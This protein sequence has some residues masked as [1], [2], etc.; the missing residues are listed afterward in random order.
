M[1]RFQLNRVGFLLIALV[2][3]AIRVHP[4][5]LLVLCATLASAS[6]GSAQAPTRR[7]SVRVQVI[8]NGAL[9]SAPTRYWLAAAPTFD[10]GGLEDDPE[11]E[12]NARR[13]EVW[14]VPLRSGGLA[15]LDVSRVQVFSS[16]G[17]RLHVIG[18]D[19]SGPREFRAVYTGCS[20]A[21]DTLLI[22][23]G[24]LS[25]LSVL[26]PNGTFVRTAQSDD[27]RAV[28]H[29]GCLSDGSVVAVRTIERRGPK[30]VVEVVRFD[31]QGKRLNIV[32]RDPDAEASDIAVGKGLSVIGRGMSVYVSD[33]REIRMF[34]RDGSLLRLF[35]TSDP[36]ES[37]TDA[38]YER[39][40]GFV[41]PARAASS[42]QRR[43]SI[44]RALARERRSAWPLFDRIIPDDEG[45]VWVQHFRRLSE[46]A[47]AGPFSRDVWTAFDSLGRLDARLELPPPVRRD[48][49]PPVVVAFSR[50]GVLLKERDD[51]GAVHFR[52][53]ELIRA[54]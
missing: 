1:P 2:R 5:S 16:T 11:L 43:S 50:G 45:R 18:R 24:S 39:E 19:G 37:I 13:G 35:R 4:R 28:G 17:R 14:A 34:R 20:L 29:Y 51:D 44:E 48:R 7:E 23:D 40:L 31:A 53:Y 3:L 52:R 8:Q 12:F 54:R 32:L 6:V 22:A 41:F 47:A 27:A 38:E 21:G 42:A 49:P 33:G 25:R 9:S 46:V 36:V 15:V 26:A 30:A 10:V